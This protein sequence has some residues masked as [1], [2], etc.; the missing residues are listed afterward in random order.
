MKHCA[1]A[2]S[3][4]LLACSGECS[5]QTL[6][7][8]G[9]FPGG[10]GSSLEAVSADGRVAI[11]YADLNGGGRAFRWTREGGM[12]SLGALEGSGDSYPGGT[13]SDGSVIVGLCVFGIFGDHTAAFRWTAVTGMQP[14]FPIPGPDSGAAA[15]SADGLVVAGI[16]DRAAFVWSAAGGTVWLGILPG[17]T[18]CEVRGISADGS[19]VVGGSDNYDSGAAFR[20]SAATGMTSLGVLPGGVSSLARA[21]SG[22]GSTVVGSASP[23]PADYT[24]TF[25]WT[26]AGGIRALDSLPGWPGAIADATNI[27]GSAVVGFSYGINTWAATLWSPTLGAVDLNDY[28]PSL[29]LDLTGWALYEATGVSADGRTIVGSGVHNGRGEGWVVTLPPAHH[30]GSADFDGD[31]QSATDADIAAFFA[32]LAGNCCPTCG[33]ADFNG[34]ADTATDADIESFFRVLGGGSC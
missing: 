28:L 9:V 16:Q 15:V 17:H 33:S 31:G 1:L 29:G 11:G 22:D 4:L 10:T 14:L 12:E 7:G 24:Q 20:W 2:A 8:V 13:N 21:I 6:T 34:D 30:C 25:E 19:V 23:V 18:R 27:D 26:G 5:A 32:C 3:G